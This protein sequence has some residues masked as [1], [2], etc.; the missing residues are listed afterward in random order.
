MFVVQE[1]LNRAHTTSEMFQRGTERE[2]R[3]FLVED[4]EEHM[5]RVFSAYGTLLTLV[6]LFR[7]LGLTISSTDDNWPV[8]E[9]NI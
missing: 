7:H 8:A 9:Q 4:T 5:G 3:S 6:S 2:Q 1:A